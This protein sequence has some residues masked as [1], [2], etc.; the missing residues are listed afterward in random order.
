M[1][2]GQ[3]NKKNAQEETKLDPKIEKQ[4]MDGMQK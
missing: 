4:I 2:P 3:F 1:K